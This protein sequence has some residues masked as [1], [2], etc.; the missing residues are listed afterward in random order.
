[1]AAWAGAAVRAMPVVAAASATAVR[2]FFGEAMRRTM[3]V[4]D[5]ENLFFGDWDVVAC[6]DP[7][8]GG[9]GGMPRR[10]GPEGTSAPCDVIQRNRIGP[11]PQ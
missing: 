2:A 3:R 11:R 5:T 10:R 6:R 4:T 1:M 8:V 7:V 9:G